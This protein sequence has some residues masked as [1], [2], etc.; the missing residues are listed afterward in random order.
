MRERAGCVSCADCAVRSRARTAFSPVRSRARTPALFARAVR[1]ACT[2]RSCRLRNLPRAVCSPVRT[3]VIEWCA[4]VTVW[5]IE[6]LSRAQAA[7]YSIV[8]YYIRRRNYPLPRF[9]SQFM[10]LFVAWRF[11]K[12]YEEKG[13]SMPTLTPEMKTFIENNLAWIAT[14]SPEGELNIGPKMSM[15]VVDDNHLGFHER[16]A[17][18]HY[19]NMVAGSPLVIAFA[20]LEEKAGYRFRGNVVLHTD[21]DLYKQQVEVANQ[22]G[23]KV[24]AAIPVLEITR[25]EDLSAGAKAG[26]TIA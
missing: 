5:Y 10:H 25:I 21:D 8:C 20:N 17:G 6:N 4:I 16:T 1:T 7:A 13:L 24:P 22:R 14:V 3:Y 18:K 15:Y 26:T 2:V 23:T 11:K 12:L 9:L 19:H